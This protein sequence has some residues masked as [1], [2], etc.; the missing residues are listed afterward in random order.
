MNVRI[1]IYKEA[2][3]DLGQEVFLHT[4]TDLTAAN[5]GI[6]PDVLGKHSQPCRMISFT[7]LCQRITG[8]ISFLKLDCEGSEYGILRSLSL[9]RVQNIAAEFHS[10]PGSTPKQGIELLR[11]Q[12]FE[13]EGRHGCPAYRWGIVWARNR[14]NSL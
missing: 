14:V 9:N 4:G 5:I 12:G 6:E 3:G 8:P 11:E 2:V 10:V 7:D 13:V 1:Q